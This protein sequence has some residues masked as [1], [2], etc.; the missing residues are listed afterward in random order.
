MIFMADSCGTCSYARRHNGSLH[1]H[2]SAPQ[3][4]GILMWHPV[5]D[6]DWCGRFSAAPVADGE[7][8]GS[9]FF[10]RQTG[11]RL[12]CHARVPYDTGWGS[13]P[14]IDPQDWCGNFST[15]RPTLPEGEETIPEAPTEGGPYGRYGGSWQP[16]LSNT[17]PAIASG[18]L[19]FSSDQTG[20]I[21]YGGGRIYKEAGGGVAFQKPQGGQPFQIENYGGGGGQNIATEPWVMSVLPEGG[22]VGP[23]GPP[24]PTG[25]TGPAGPPGDAAAAASATVGDVKQGFQGADH[26]GWIKL[27]GRAT[28]TLTATQQEAATYLGFAENLPDA[29]GAV[30]MADGE[31]L[32]T[33]GGSM[34][35]T[36]T[37]ANL[38]A[39]TLTTAAAGVHY[40]QAQACTN[41]E[42]TVGFS[43]ML[44]NYGLNIWRRPAEIA[45]VNNQNLFMLGRMMEDAGEHTHDVPLGGAGIALDITP[46]SLS[47]NCF[48]WLGD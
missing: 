36:L 9:C 10:A 17:A 45:N 47:V 28:A 1:C 41:D 6:A 26:G 22:A 7:S 31:L 21:L 2:V 23:A 24:G 33:V 43:E 30:P 14:A 46:K 11:A 27:D 32:G 18:W 16:V 39:I 15:E 25:A 12:N 38:P 48:V 44:A 42:G 13:W 34:T 20:I 37:Q 3:D 8:C 40:H 35:R 19:T 5:A 4:A 29:T